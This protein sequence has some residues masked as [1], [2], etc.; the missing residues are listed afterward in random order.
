[1]NYISNTTYSITQHWISYARLCAGFQIVTWILFKNS[2]KKSWKKVD[3]Y[4]LIIFLSIHV[5]TSSGNNMEW[6]TSLIY[7]PTPK[8]TGHHLQILPHICGYTVCPSNSVCVF[9]SCINSRAALQVCRMK[10]LNVLHGREEVF[11]Q[12]LT[13]IAGKAGSTLLSASCPW[14]VPPRRG[15]L[16][17]QPRPRRSWCPCSQ[18]VFRRTVPPGALWRQNHNTVAL[19]RRSEK[20]ELLFLPWTTAP[21]LGLEKPSPFTFILRRMPPSLVRFSP[22]KSSSSICFVV[23]VELD[24]VQHRYIKQDKAQGSAQLG[25]GLGG[26]QDNGHKKNK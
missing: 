22:L 23:N 11:V 25:V 7:R 3:P 20:R 17:L 1:M 15:R 18:T 14:L 8:Y 13:L 6:D 9:S 4:L 21:S 16:F 24:V 10:A 19:C 2:K 5:N 26:G 12:R